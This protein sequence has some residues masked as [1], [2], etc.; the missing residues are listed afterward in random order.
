[1]A[2]PKVAIVYPVDLPC[3]VTAPLEW[4]ERRELSTLPGPRQSRV[5]TRDQYGTQQLTFKLRSPAQVQAW[6]EWGDVSL[7]Q[8]GN[9]FAAEWPV[10]YGGVAVRRF[11][12]APS[13]PEYL[14]RI[15]AWVVSANV[16]IRGRGMLPYRVVSNCVEA[17]GFLDVAFGDVAGT[18]EY[19][20]TTPIPAPEMETQLSIMERSAGAVG[21][22]STFPCV[23]ATTWA[24][25]PDLPLVA[26]YSCTRD[27][28][29]VS[30]VSF[31]LTI[32]DIPDE[33]AAICKCV[34]FQTSGH[35]TNGGTV[36]NG[37]VTINGESLG[38]G[39]F[40]ALPPSTGA[41]TGYVLLRNNRGDL[42]AAFN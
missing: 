41:L 40:Q 8:W 32:T 13:Y 5:L 25:L 6:L 37:E 4:A 19:V 23:F 28:S 38:P 1:M 29:G 15:G 18:R 3:P 12:G 24:D 26:Y 7:G 9:W 14:P 33:G 16:E 39:V 42:T 21:P 11:V 10:S 30:T 31:A 35:W 17:S 20:S 22:G 2:V 36:P 27:G 34:M